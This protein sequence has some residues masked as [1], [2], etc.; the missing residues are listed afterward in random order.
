MIRTRLRRWIAA[1]GRVQ[2]IVVALAAMSVAIMYC[3]NT[4]ED[5]QLA[6]PRGDGRYRP[7]I[8]RGDGHMHFLVTRSIVFDGDFNFDNDLA[9]FGD[10]WNQ[11][12]TVT[13]RK[14][15]M[16]Q[17]GP[18]LIWAP[19]LAVA[20]GVA[21][22]ANVFGA[23]IETHGYTMF[24]Q[25]IL[26]VSSVVFAVLAIVLGVAVALRL[27]GGRW[28]AA[29]AAVSV[30]LGTT[31]TYY[32]TYM[33]SYAHA[34][35]AAT[36]AAFLA[37]WALTLRDLRWRRFVILGVLLGVATN[38]RIQDVGF[39]VVVAIEI[40]AIAIELWRAGARA[41]IPALFARGAVALAIVIAMFIPQLYVW[42]Q[43]YGTWLTTP[44]GPGQM[45]YS[46]PLVMELLFSP[47]NGWLS[48]TPLAWFGVIGLIV[49]VF[50]G[51]RLGRHARF[52]CAGMLAVIAGQIYVNAVTYEWWSGASFSQRRLCSVS[53]P[54]VVGI[55]AGLRYMHLRIGPRLS[56]AARQV[57]AV[58][59]LGYF[60]AWN[61][62]WVSKLDHGRPAGRDNE[63]TCCADVPAPLSWIARPIYAV[64][65]NPFELPASAWFAI[66][67]GV[68]LRRWDAVNGHYPLVPPVLG[69]EDGSYRR[70]HAVWDIAG[71][72]GEPYLLHGFGPPQRDANRKWRWTTSDDAALI[73]SILMPE[74]HRIT[75]PLA[76]NAAAGETV[77]IEIETGG[78]VSRATVGAAWTTMTI[79]TDGS[80][81]ENTITIRAPA[82]SYRGGPAAGDL[83]AVGVA[84]GPLQVGLP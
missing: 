49:G 12:R 78:N 16:Q 33:P 9:R 56:I 81:G 42:D 59:I 37:Y 30:L 70:A 76:A 72:G 71:P 18:S 32:A 14:N 50:V 46:H 3:G 31:L 83:E 11:P 67:H 38:V 45:R 51:E 27:F 55:A 35:D 74:P 79:D 24:H 75:I 36:C 26:F 47:R 62:N 65:G 21:T 17:I 54:L 1:L 68:D 34:M 61:L 84:I 80:L 60:V 52:V 73:V 48:N 8:A 58:A 7:A 66:R 53:L 64:V 41:A 25:R 82:R 29:W 15:V 63:P 40:A 57:I 19:I 20:H 28:A 10:P 4:N 77:D 5:P 44:Q 2:A 39:G 22:V 23:D 43:M 69:Y 6:G 13:G